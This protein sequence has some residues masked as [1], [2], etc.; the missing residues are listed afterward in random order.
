MPRQATFALFARDAPVAIRCRPERPGQ[1]VRHGRSVQAR[2]IDDDE[3]HHLLR[4]VRR[5]S[6]RVVTWRGAQMVLL[7]AEECGRQLRTRERG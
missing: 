4:I 3:G 6:G 7:L 1:T 2:E 5:G